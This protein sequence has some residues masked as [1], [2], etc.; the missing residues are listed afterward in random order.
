MLEEVPRRLTLQLLVRIHEFDFRHHF[1]FDC[2]CFSVFLKIH[3]KIQ[4]KLV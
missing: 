1:N 4:H 2:F 3:K